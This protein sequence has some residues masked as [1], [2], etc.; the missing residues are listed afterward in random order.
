MRHV[1]YLMQVIQEMDGVWKEFGW[2]VCVGMRWFGVGEPFQED[3]GWSEVAGV[4]V[5]VS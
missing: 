4:L 5:K 2:F 1:V 3:L